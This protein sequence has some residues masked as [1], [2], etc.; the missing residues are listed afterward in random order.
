MREGFKDLMMKVWNEA[1]NFRIKCD[2]IVSLRTAWPLWMGLRSN[3]T[4]AVL[5][6]KHSSQFYFKFLVL[7]REPEDRTSVWYTLLRR[8]ESSAVLLCP[9][10]TAA[11]G[12]FTEQTLGY[13]LI[14]PDPKWHPNGAL[15]VI[16]LIMCFGEVFSLTHSPSVGSQ[17]HCNSLVSH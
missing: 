2:I 16:L 9:S 13:V 4:N 3:V 12:T 10:A 6:I 5:L 8:V 15:E 1:E 11:V 14:W 7:E 17:L